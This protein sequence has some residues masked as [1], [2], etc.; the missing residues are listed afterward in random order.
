MNIKIFFDE[1]L[2]QDQTKFKTLIKTINSLEDPNDGLSLALKFNNLTKD[3]EDSLISN[4]FIK[5]LPPNFKIN[6]W[7]NLEVARVYFLME[8]L[9]KFDKKYDFVVEELFQTAGISE[10]VALYKSLPFLPEPVKFLSRAQEGARSNINLIFNAIALNNIYPMNFFDENTWNHLVLK[11]FFIE[12]D[13]SQIIGLQKR[14]N[15]TLVHMLTDFANE[16]IAAG[17]EVNP[18]LW[19]VIKLSQDRLS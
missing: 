13:V 15:P 3:Y 9:N 8:I 16:R 14:A 2:Q 10:L 17:R 11:A 5:D 4:L 18:R 19:K 6:T 12:S 1:I 7:T